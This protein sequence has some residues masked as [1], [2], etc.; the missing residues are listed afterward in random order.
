MYVIAKLAICSINL[1]VR[2]DDVWGSVDVAPSFLTSALNGGEWSASLPGRFI[3]GKEPLVLIEKGA[4]CAPEPV[5]SL[6]SRTK[7]VFSAGN[8]SPAVQP[9]A[10]PTTPSRLYKCNSSKLK[11]VDF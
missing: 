2:R 10:I 5:W 8:R 6:S 1:A 11:P 7:S 4:V 3:P 9:V